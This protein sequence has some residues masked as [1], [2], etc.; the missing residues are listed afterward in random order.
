MPGFQEQRAIHFNRLVMDEM[1]DECPCNNGFSIDDEGK[2]RCVDCD[3][4]IGTPL[5]RFWDRNDPDKMSDEDWEI[6][7]E[8]DFS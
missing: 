6:Y 8:I 1:L 4:I 3:R 5:S 7:R 2:S